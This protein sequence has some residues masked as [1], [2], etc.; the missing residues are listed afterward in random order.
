MA[1]SVSAVHRRP[2]PSYLPCPTSAYP[3][4][5]HPTQSYPSYPPSGRI[6]RELA[7][8]GYAAGVVPPRA[9]CLC[10]GGTLRISEGCST[11]LEN[12]RNSL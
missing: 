7:P 12:V 8:E 3:D 1:G 10:P 5:P 9:A 4:L 6:G 2:T 11:W